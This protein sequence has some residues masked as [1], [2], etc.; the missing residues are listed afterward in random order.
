MYWRHVA[1][2]SAA[3]MRVAQHQ[4]DGFSAGGHDRDRLVRG[5][6]WQSEPSNLCRSC[7]ADVAT[8]KKPCPRHPESPRY[9]SGGCIACVTQRVRAYR[10]AQRKARPPKPL[11]ARQRAIK[12]GRK[13]YTTRCR[14][15]GKTLHRTRDSACLTC[16]RSYYPRRLSQQTRERQRLQHRLYSRRRAR[17]LRLVRELGLT[18]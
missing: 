14:R 18:L 5:R 7:R 8:M 6:I 3:K 9:P 4:D 15:H 16:G 12:A 10:A 2:A 17:A 11:S 1:A 13:Y